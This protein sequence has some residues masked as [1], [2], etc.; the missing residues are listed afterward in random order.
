MDGEKRLKEGAQKCHFSMLL[1]STGKSFWI[2]SPFDL[3]NM[4]FIMVSASRCSWE[5]SRS[6]WGLS[7]T[8]WMVFSSSGR[9]R[10]PIASS[11]VLLLSIVRAPACSKPRDLK[12]GNYFV[13]QISPLIISLLFQ[14]LEPS[15]F[16]RDKKNT[17]LTHNMSLLG[18][19]VMFS[20]NQ[21]FHIQFLYPIHHIPVLI[22][23]PN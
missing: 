19:G 2:N 10:H 18:G 4:W 5:M 16:A 9:A 22:I 21:G 15:L 7:T 20:D 8:P 12:Y 1:C 3:K 11:A 14:D 23:S 13:F 6:P 17:S